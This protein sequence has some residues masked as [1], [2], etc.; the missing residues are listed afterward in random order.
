MEPTASFGVSKMAVSVARNRDLSHGGYYVNPGPGIGKSSGTL[1]GLRMH[2]SL[3]LSYDSSTT[4]PVLFHPPV[5]TDLS[6]WKFLSP[7]N[8]GLHMTT[9][10][11]DSVS[12]CVV[13]AI[14]ANGLVWISKKGENFIVPTH[15]SCGHTLGYWPTMDRLLKCQL[16]NHG[17]ILYGQETRL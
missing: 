13:S 10:D 8:R 1:A 16:P 11:L 14:T 9:H 5:S 12:S 7:H 6:Y 2:Y 17:P 4:L 3:H 15:I